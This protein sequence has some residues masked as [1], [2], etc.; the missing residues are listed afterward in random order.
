MSQVGDVKTELAALTPRCLLVGSSGHQGFPSPW[1]LGERPKG[2]GTQK[3]KGG[4]VQD[5][6]PT[7]TSPACER[8]RVQSGA[9]GD[10]RRRV[11]ADVGFSAYSRQAQERRIR[12]GRGAQS[13]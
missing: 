8:Q 4:V 6:T 2:R 12:T 3:A 9:A 5:G 10:T 7:V 13:C 1:T 11:T